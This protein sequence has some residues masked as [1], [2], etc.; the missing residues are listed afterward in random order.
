MAVEVSGSVLLLKRV[1]DPFAPIPVTETIAEEDID[2]FGEY[3]QLF[4]IIV[5]GQRHA[6]P[7]D[8]SVLRGL[9]YLEIKH[10]C[11]KMPWASYCWNDTEGCCDMTYR[12][13]DGSPE[14]GRACRVAAEPGLEILVLPK[15][16]RLA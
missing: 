2:L 10:A 15:G 11:V 6:V 1:D 12:T 14:T 3:R 7:E 13:R 16:G 4:P 8:N 9:Q 5:E